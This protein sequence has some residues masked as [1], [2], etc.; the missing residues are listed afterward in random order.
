MSVIETTAALRMPAEWELHSRCWL[1]WPC[2]EDL[3]GNHLSKAQQEFVALCRAISGI[4]LSHVSP[5][6][7]V[8]VL[9]RPDCEAS[10]KEALDGI[11]CRLFPAEYGD[12]WLRDTGPIFVHSMDHLVAACFRFN[13][14]GGKFSLPHDDRVAHQITSFIDSPRLDLDWVF[15]GGAIDVDGLG[16]GLTT[17]QCLLNPN[18]GE[19]LSEK[20]VEHRLQK[21]LGIRKTI[22]I[23]RGLLNDHTDG[24]VD[25][26]ARFV[27]PGAVIC[28]IARD[29]EDPN[30]E[31]LL[32]IR[33]TL[34]RATDVRG[35]PLRLIEAPSP[36]AVLNEGGE[37]MPASYLNFYISNRTVVV[38]TYGSAWDGPAVDAISRCFPTRKTIGLPAKTILSGGGAFHC[39][40]Q[41]QPETDDDFETD[42][43]PGEEHV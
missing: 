22:W 10:A 3:W 30:R 8:F 5:V 37:V 41:Q 28:M 1:A 42:Q 16:T 9:V 31:T 25:T 20:T 33:E 36:G 23:E 43:G 27:G 2:A 40:T 14:W 15:E 35:N 17:R 13:G 18:R 24:H 11:P 4:G 38:P 7:P 39:I 26:I 21:A 34:A 29:A 19:G 32:E 12:I 6:E